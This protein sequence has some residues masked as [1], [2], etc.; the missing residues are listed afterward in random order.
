MPRHILIACMPK[1]AS[2]FLS[3]AIAEIT[4]FQK[5]VLVPHFGRREQEFCEIRVSEYDKI[6]YVTQQHIRNS[7]YTSDLC[8][9]HG[10]VPIVLVRSLFDV[11]VSLRDHSRRES[12]IGPSLYLDESHVG[13][14]DRALETMISKLAVPWY[15]NFYLS[16]RAEKEA[17]IVQYEDLVADPASALRDILKFSGVS[18][19]QEAIQAGLSRT[20]E[21]S[22]SRLNVGIAGRGAQ[23]APETIRTILEMIDLYPEIAGDPYIVRMKSQA[24]QLLSTA[25]EPLDPAL[26]QR[27]V[28]VVSPNATGS[29]M[30]PEWLKLAIREVKRLGD[31][32]RRIIG[33]LLIV[34]GLVHF[35]LLSEVIPDN[36]EL[37]RLDDVLIPVILAYIAGR[38]MTRRRNKVI[39]VKSD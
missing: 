15:I 38:F 39:R 22:A 8:A 17:K 12:P 25:N 30:V 20:K 28:P 31:S 36:T 37:G 35:F 3:N 34:L 11:V 26:A 14:D 32:P 9:S 18:A 1:S 13:L 10:I 6:D 27:Y 33:A 4:G 23:L 16:W 7:R 5:V 2:T 19:S 21:K 29:S 24:E